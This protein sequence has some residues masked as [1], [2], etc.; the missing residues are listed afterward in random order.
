MGY[1][2]Y[3]NADVMGISGYT[4]ATPGDIVVVR[5]ALS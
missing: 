1:T 4:R 3:T 2:S 5:Y